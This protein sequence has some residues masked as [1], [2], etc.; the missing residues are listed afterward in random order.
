MINFEVE[1]KLYSEV[2]NTAGLGPRMKHTG[3]NAR[4]A[5]LSEQKYPAPWCGDFYCETIPA[6]TEKDR[7]CFVASLLAMTCWRAAWN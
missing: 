5:Y 4:S 1:L 2:A 3:I 7:D 6:L